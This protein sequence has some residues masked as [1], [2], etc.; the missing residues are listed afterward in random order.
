MKLAVNIQTLLSLSLWLVYL[1]PSAECFLLRARRATHLF[2][3]DGVTKDCINRNSEVATCI[4]SPTLLKSSASKDDENP[5]NQLSTRKNFFTEEVVS[6][7]SIETKPQYD[8]IVGP[9][10]RFMDRIFLVVFRKQLASKTGI[11]SSRDDTDYLGIIDIS[12]R[13]NK[14]F[15]DRR[16]VQQKAK[17]VLIALFPGWLP[18]AYARLF[19]RPF[20]AFS[21]RMN[22][23]T[24]KVAGTWLM[25]ETEVNDVQI[26]GGKIGKSQ[27]LLVK[28]CRFLEES[29]CASVC[30]NSCKIPT[31]SF[32]IENM[33]LPLTMEPNY[34]TFECQFS[35]GRTP[36]TTTE[37]LAKNVPCLSRCPTAGAL[38]KY[39]EDRCNL[40]EDGENSNIE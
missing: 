5:A 3:F 9:L 29:G 27:G 24:T 6:G 2:I 17:E 18:P 33:G 8:N 16:V 32:F 11:D 37:L 19:S 34:E 14:K 39:H 35:F 40:M 28:R 15:S 26:D 23:W 12:L 31:Q 7:P 21:S 25:G 13:M 22:A 38:R 1:L 36:D 30:V 10:G 20:P 4:S